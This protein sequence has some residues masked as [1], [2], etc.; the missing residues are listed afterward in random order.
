VDLTGR[1]ALV[2]G[3]GRGIGRAVALYLAELGAAVALNDL[4]PASGAEA[5]AEDIRLGG[6]QSLPCPADVRRIDQIDAMMK[7]VVERFGRLDIL[8]NNAGI[9][10][11]CSFFDT[12]G[13][14][15]DD[16]LDTN[17]KGVFFCAQ[18]AAREMRKTG[19]GRIINVS[20]VHGQATMPNLA[21]YAASKGGID[22]LTR[23][24]SLDLAPFR[25]T[26]NAVAPG[27]VQVEK[28]TFDPAVRGREIPAGRVGT[29][30]DIASTIGFLASDAAQWL[31]GQV[32]TI[33]GGTTARLCLDH[34]T[35][36]R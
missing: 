4:A 16:V 20:S 5:T 24:L 25:I 6:G 33:D 9:D 17:L 12:S 14:F 32:I 29:P 7:A 36:P 28:N 23:Q 8:V 13:E 34:G 26:V 22:A 35:T 11:R 18:S 27:C 19:G 15:W 10:P 3:A 21:A 2:T 1:V 31:T 30:Q